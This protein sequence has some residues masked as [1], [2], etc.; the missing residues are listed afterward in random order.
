[1]QQPTRAIRL[2][3]ALAAA[4][5]GALTAGAAG[6]GGD[7]SPGDSAA[8][9]STEASDHNRVD[10]DFATRMIPHHA[11]ALSMLD[12]SLGRPLDPDVEALVE[13][14]RD[15]QAPEIETMADWLT[16]WGEEVPATMRDHEHAEDATAELPSMPGMATAEEMA[17][18]EQAPDETFQDLLLQMMVEHHRGAVEMATTEQEQGRFAPARELAQRI[19]TS[20]TEEIAVMESLLP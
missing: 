15:A 19:V 2:R 8:S 17:E 13:R 11:Q 14:I 5:L 9:G 20:Q 18:L 12:L 10:V 16:S 4:L 7:P 1:M 3:S 6:C